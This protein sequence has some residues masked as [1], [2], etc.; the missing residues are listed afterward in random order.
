MEKDTHSKVTIKIPR[1]LYEKLQQVVTGTG[2]DSVTDLVVYV[3]RDLAAT[4]E[5]AETEPYT[6]QELD[7]VKHRLKNLG[8]L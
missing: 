5:L 8:Y 4:H 2:Y 1:P 7:M 6:P 3:L